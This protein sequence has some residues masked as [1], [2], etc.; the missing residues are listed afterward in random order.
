MQNR[1]YD[2]KHKK[3]CQFSLKRALKS[4]G[5]LRKTTCFRLLC[6]SPRISEEQKTQSKKEYLK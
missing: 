1:L 2:R 5:G 3:Q 6:I 4:G